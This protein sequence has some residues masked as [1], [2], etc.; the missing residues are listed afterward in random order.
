ME[1]KPLSLLVVSM[2]RQLT[3]CFSPSMFRQVPGG[4]LTRRLKRHCVVICDGSNRERVER[5]LRAPLK[6]AAKKGPPK[7]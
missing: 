6:N 5:L 7:K 4:S 2:G 1:N 3:G